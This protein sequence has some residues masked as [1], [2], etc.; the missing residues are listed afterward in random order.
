MTPAAPAQACHRG[1]GLGLAAPEEGA[2]ALLTLAV[3]AGP[4]GEGDEEQPG[5]AYIVPFAALTAIQDFLRRG[6]RIDHAT[7]QIEP[8]PR[9]D[10]G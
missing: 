2:R 9:G 7:I 6:Y 10:E 8:G 1:I 4:D 3:V 5:Q